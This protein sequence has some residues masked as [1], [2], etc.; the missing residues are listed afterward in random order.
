MTSV[1][2]HYD[3]SSSVHRDIHNRSESLEDRSDHL[4]QSLQLGTT[5]C[6]GLMRHVLDCLGALRVRAKFDHRLTPAIRTVFKATCDKFLH[7]VV[8]DQDHEYVDGSAVNLLMNVFPDESKR[9][10]GRS[11]LPLHWASAIDTTEEED[12]KSIAR[13]RP[14]NAKNT[15]EAGNMKLN[16][17]CFYCS[18]KFDCHS[19]AND[20]KGLRVFKYAKGPT[21][22]T[23]VEVTP[24]VEELL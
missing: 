4:M 20:G 8:E 12:I 15:H 22:L 13:D 11:W 14:V 17:G 19:D 18:Y 10:D 23:T 1:L 6:Q 7:A 16:K 9:R 2:S 5:D 21:Y 3:A 24:R